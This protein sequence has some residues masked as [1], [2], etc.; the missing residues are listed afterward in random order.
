MLPGPRLWGLALLGSTSIIPILIGPIITGVLVDYGGFDDRAAGLTAGYGAIGS[1]SVALICALSMHRLPLRKLAFA[2]VCLAVIGN[3]GAAVFYQWHD[4]FYA[5][6][7]VTA[8]GD[9]A[10]YAA[11]MSAFAREAH[12]ERC[13]GMFMMLQFGLAALGLWGLPTF[14]PEMNASEMFLGFFA[15]NLG[16]FLLVSLLPANAADIAGMTIRAREWRLLLSVPALAGL[17]ALFF[18]ESSNIGTDAYM[19]RIAVLAGYGDE[20]IGTVLGTAS[21]LGVPGAF[22]IMFVSGRFGHALPVLSGVALG[23]VSLMGLMQAQSYSVFFVWTCVHSVSWAFTTPYIQSILANM[24]PGG[25]VVTAG[26]IASGAG[27]GAGPS[28]MAMLVSADDYSGVL[29]ISLA[30]Y[31]LAA[32][33][34][35]IVSRR[36]SAVQLRGA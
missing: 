29:T 32:V 10:I 36:M 7:I 26:G 20:K 3:L 6:R 4:V 27:A 21:L 25:A 22:A 13:Y 5:F 23:V 24:D 33:A 18:F 15:L 1:V 16:A 31:G 12:S 2:G 28:A 11:V 34:I 9:G 35:V 8:L 30:A 19:E 17:A 14:F